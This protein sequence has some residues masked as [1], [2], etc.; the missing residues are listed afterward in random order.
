MQKFQRF[1]KLCAGRVGQIFNA[2]NLGNEL[3]VSAKTIQRWLSVLESSF[4]IFRLQPYYENLGKRV[5][6]APKLY[7]NDVGLVTYLL[8]ITS[9]EQLSRD[10][11]RG[12]L[13]ENL[14]ILECMKSCLNDGIEQA[15]Y[16]YRD[17][18][19]N[20]IDLLFRVGNSLV[21]IEIKSSQTFS[22]GFLKNIKYFKS[23]T[24]ERCPVEFL[25]YS[26]KQEQSIGSCHILNYKNTA[27]IFSLSK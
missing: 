2:L 27:K 3:G 20:E 13:V 6:K 18:N 15:F 17:S 23:L 24:A 4:L 16:Y 7:F 19:N 21:P 12:G 9:I 5:N 8:D 11:L 10:P 25:I 1:L 26:G 14:V 22:S